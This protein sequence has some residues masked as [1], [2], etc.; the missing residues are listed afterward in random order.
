MWLQ[1]P[2]S[3]LRAHVITATQ[4]TSGSWQFAGEHNNSGWGVSYFSWH[5]ANIAGDRFFVL[6]QL[7][8]HDR[9][10]GFKAATSHI[11]GGL[12]EETLKK[13]Y[14]AILDTC[15]KKRQGPSPAEPFWSPIMY[16]GAAAK[17][18]DACVAKEARYMCT[19]KLFSEGLKQNH[20][21]VRVSKRRAV[22]YV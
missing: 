22:V 8:T 15:L 21:L 19:R 17:D 12:P 2:F 3:E 9:D 18:K 20:E 6:H 5:A 14:E 7:S 4:T 13:P 11:S 1:K 16:S 10:D